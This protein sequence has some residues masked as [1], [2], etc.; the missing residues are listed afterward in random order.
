MKQLKRIAVFAC[1]LSVGLIPMLSHAT[2]LKAARD[3]TLQKD[4]VVEGDLYVAAQTNV[5]SGEVKGDLGVAG[6]NTLITGSV[7]QDL[8][9]VGGTVELLGDVGDD[10]RAAGGTITVG[11]TVGGDVV[12]A[13][14]V[15]HIISGATVEGDVIVAGGQVIIDGVVKGNVKVA[16]GEVAINGEVGKDVSVRSDRQFTLGKDAKIAGAIWYKAPST[17]VITEGASIQG[18]P[19]F[20]KIERPTRVDKRAQAA[21][22]GLVGV[23]ALIKLFIMLATAIVGV[24]LF[25]KAMQGLVK[26]TVNYF[27]RELV[28]GFVLLIVVPAAIVLAMISL[29]GIWFAFAGMLLYILLVMMAK[30]LASIVLGIVLVKM[31]K[32]TNEYEVSWQNA[33]IGVVAIE[34]IGLVP[35][36]GWVAVFL[37]FLASLGSISL[38]LYQKTWIKR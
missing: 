36:L 21:M 30:V 38:M 15:I 32:K 2:E 24:L 35:V 18:E 14:G 16:A 9:V 23:T 25:K 20:V 29:I 5:F 22:A 33:A 4:G 28:R 26:T 11:K 37:L 8:F 19:T 31:I 3:Y 10:L 27:G 17:L 1:V 34:L 6:A 12:A 7:D 13:G